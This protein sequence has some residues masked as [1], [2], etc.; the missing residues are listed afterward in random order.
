MALN[1]SR[2]GVSSAQTIRLEIEY[3]SVGNFY[4]NP[5]NTPSIQVLAPD[6]VTPG[7]FVVLVPTTTTGVIQQSTGIFYY[8]YVVPVGAT[9]GAWEDVWTTSINNVP[10]VG[11]FNFNV[12][13]EQ[14]PIVV[15]VREKIAPELSD[16]ANENIQF[17][18]DLLKNRLG[19][20]GKKRQTDKYGQYITDGAG[21]FILQDCDIFTTAELYSF[22]RAS[23]AE[24]NMIPHW[25]H[26]TFEDTHIIHLYQEL[27]TEGAYILSL[28][29]QSLAEKGREFNITDD[30]TSF[31]PPQLGEFMM[32]II[33]ALLTSYRDRIKYIKVNYK[34]YPL[35]IGSVY[36][37]NST[38]NNNGNGLLNPAYHRLSHL[39][40][41][42]I[43]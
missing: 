27:F 21:N 4:V 36:G 34:P 19:S 41:R 1:T 8:D 42:K 31:Q 20:D 32:G 10:L 40:A 15:Q 11:N 24:F 37:M 30:G 35:S 14:Q 3:F 12:V 25:T 9:L 28:I 17:L 43:I 18:I 29:K 13:G 5:D 6:P 2:I 38:S 33:N 26:F 23:L 39:R 22:L 7:N 16:Q